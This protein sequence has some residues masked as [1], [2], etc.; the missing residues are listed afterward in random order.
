MGGLSRLAGSFHG[1]GLCTLFTKQVNTEK[2]VWPDVIL[3]EKIASGDVM[4][5]LGRE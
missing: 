3:P 5:A 4:I 2:C 1:R